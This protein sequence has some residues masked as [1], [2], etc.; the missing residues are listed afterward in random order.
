MPDDNNRLATDSG[1]ILHTIVRAG[2]GTVPVAGS[3]LT[4]TFNLLF[5]SPVSRR[6]DQW[7]AEIAGELREL[8]EG[9]EGFSIE[10]L[11]RN[12]EFVTILLN[13]TQI[14]IRNHQEEKRTALRNAVV[15]TA[16]GINI[17]ENEK[18]MFVNLIDRLTPLHLKL[19][20]LFK[21]PSDYNPGVRNHPMM[22]IVELLRYVFPNQDIHLVEVALK[23]LSGM[24]L[25]PE[26]GVH[27]M[28]TSPGVIARR[29]T[30]FGLK[31]L[32]F[33]ST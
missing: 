27:T 29:T 12:E 23:D 11:T 9:V 13:A 22:S 28:Q 33:I 25:L 21:N 14:A 8:Q 18:L 3:I 26:I 6:R 4:E 19:I 10:N 31:F 7:I 16:K 2:L 32:E 24:N 1:E 17:D 30:D 20:L 15:N 5:A